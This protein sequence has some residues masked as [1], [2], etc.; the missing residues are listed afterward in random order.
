MPLLTL[1]LDPRSRAVTG[2][3]MLVTT[4]SQVG[5]FIEVAGARAVLA[6]SVIPADEQW[7]WTEEWQRGEIEALASLAMGDGYRFQTADELI[8]WLGSDDG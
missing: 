4:S 2:D 6:S 5:T 7:F 8:A 3:R 1:E